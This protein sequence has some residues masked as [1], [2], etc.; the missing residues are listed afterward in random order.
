LEKFT[1]EQWL[2][3]ILNAEVRLIFPLL[4]QWF[5][6]VV[7]CTLAAFGITGLLMRRVIA[8][9]KIENNCAGRMQSRSTLLIES[10]ISS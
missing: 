5:V 3:E 10:C 4:R 1:L 8:L 2:K 6:S 9:E 7:M